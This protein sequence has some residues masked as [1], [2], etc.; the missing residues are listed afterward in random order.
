MQAPVIRW[1]TNVAAFVQ[2]MLNNA[3]LKAFLASIPFSKFQLCEQ[4][5]SYNI[6]CHMASCIWP[7]AG[8]PGGDTQEYFG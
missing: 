3:M 6:C 8:R 4:N 5:E 2:Q 1:S 7:A